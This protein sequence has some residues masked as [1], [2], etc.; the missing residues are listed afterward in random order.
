KERRVGG[1]DTLIL[2]D[3]ERGSFAIPKAWTNRAAPC[4]YETIGMTPGRLDIELLLDLVTLVE[5]LT[6]QSKNGLA[7]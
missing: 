3:T 2:R 1:V 4:P 6:T 5:H 7:K